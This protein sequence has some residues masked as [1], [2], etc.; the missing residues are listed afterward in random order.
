MKSSNLNL[1]ETNVL[2]NSLRKCTQTGEEERKLSL[3]TDDMIIY[4]EN[5]KESTK[6]LLELINNY[7]KVK[8]YIV[9]I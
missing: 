5:Q 4:I 9:N 6:K 2:V 1:N 8:E 7:I 3:F